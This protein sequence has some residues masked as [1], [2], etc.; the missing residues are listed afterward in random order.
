MTGSIPEVTLDE[1]WRLLKGHPDA[2]LVDVRTE[3]EWQFV[4]VPA[5]ESVGKETVFVSW[6]R[7]PGEANTSFVADIKAAGV[8]PDHIVLL[9]CRSGARSRAAAHVLAEAGYPDCRNITAGFE[10]P[11][12]DEGHRSGG[13]KAHGLPWRQS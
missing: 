10:G 9:L 11:L 5:L 7:Y 2:V 8:R 1:A 6:S 4:G 12:D 3:P 13:W